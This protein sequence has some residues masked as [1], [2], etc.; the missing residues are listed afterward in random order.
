[1]SDIH[2]GAGKIPEA[3]TLGLADWL[4]LAAAP[5]FAVM[6]LL[7]CIFSGDAAM[8]CMGTDASP[9]TGMAA[10]YLLMSAFHLAPWLRVIS[11][12]QAR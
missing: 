12:R 10:M 11:G 3:T 8:Q 9:L 6:A 5:T 1:M 2:T 4:C 7:T